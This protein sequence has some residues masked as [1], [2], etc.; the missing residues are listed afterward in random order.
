MGNSRTLINSGNPN[1]SIRSKA[2]ALAKRLKHK[3]SIRPQPHRY[4][5]K[6]QCHGAICEP[7]ESRMLLSSGSIVTIDYQGFD[8]LPAESIVFNEPDVNAQVLN[9][10]TNGSAVTLD[11]SASNSGSGTVNVTNQL[12]VTLTPHLVTVTGSADLV[13]GDTSSIAALIATPGNDG[14]ITLREAVQAANNTVGED[15]IEFDQALLE[16][17]IELQEQLTVTEELTIRGPSDDFI[18]LSTE[19]DFAYFNVYMGSDASDLFTL[20]NVLFYSDPEC[21]IYVNP[22]NVLLD[23]VFIDGLNFKMHTEGTVTLGDMINP[24]G[25]IAIYASD[26]ISVL[27]TVSTEGLTS[28]YGGNIYFETAIGG[29]FFAYSTSLINAGLSE[30]LGNSSHIGGE[31]TWYLPD[32]EITLCE[33]WGSFITIDNTLEGYLVND[34]MNLWGDEIGSGAGNPV[35][36][37]DY[38]NNDGSNSS[39]GV[40]LEGSGSSG[41]GGGTTTVGGGGTTQ[42][43]AAPT[44][45]DMTLTAMEDGDTV[46]L[47]FDASDPDSGDSLTYQLLSNQSHGQLV[48]NGNG[49]FSYTA[50]DWQQLNDGMERDITFIYRVIDNHGAASEPATVTITIEGKTET[51]G[52]ND[53]APIGVPNFVRTDSQ[54]AID[55][56]VLA[57]D[58]TPDGDMLINSHVDAVSELGVALTVNADGTIAYDPTEALADLDPGQRVRDVFTYTVSDPFGNS[59][60]VRVFVDVTGAQTPEVNVAAQSAGQQLLAMAMYQP[61]RVHES[62]SAFSQMSRISQATSTASTLAQHFGL[63]NMDWSRYGMSGWSTLTFYHSDSSYEL[64]RW[65][66]DHFDDETQMA[67]IRSG[68][69]FIAFPTNGNAQSGSTKTVGF[70]RNLLTGRTPSQSGSGT[71]ELSGSNHM[72]TTGHGLIALS[73]ESRIGLERSESLGSLLGSG[74]INKLGP[75]TLTL[76]G[77]NTF[78]ESTNINSGTLTIDQ[79]ALDFTSTITDTINLNP[80]GN[81]TFSG[82]DLMSIS[83]TLTL[84]GAID[85]VGEDASNGSFTL[86]SASDVMT[87]SSQIT[88]SEGATLQIVPM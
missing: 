45:N 43:N 33:T 23:N 75:G 25:N 16:G 21:S 15:V 19:D 42:P 20:E 84:T 85:L 6:T 59:D 35:S 72:V 10:I 44:A 41:S 26:S 79:G 8:V 76:S 71:L 12:G 22:G 53:A 9:R 70:F 82:G 17:V 50:G 48:N 54:T 86:S 7:L 80:N 5:G 1:M 87:I 13:D 63:I 47:A 18:R 11:G 81:I 67:T 57:N 51:Q 66:V 38:D 34:E 65:F 46:T 61:R 2:Q 4:I 32:G 58:Y 78:T 64:T 73:P 28:R 37:I 30:S 24:R 14:E 27:G 39:G 36:V 74:S 52:G 83:G 60:T 49:T 69:T 31:A 3:L 29:K 68:D 40:T 56:N 55:I 77:T 88:F 62:T